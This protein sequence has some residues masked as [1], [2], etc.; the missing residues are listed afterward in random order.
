MGC[1]GNWGLSVTVPTYQPLSRILNS[2]KLKGNQKHIHLVEVKYCEEEPAH[3]HQST[4]QRES[5]TLCD[6]LCQA[7]SKGGLRTVILGVGGTL[8]SPYSK[9]TLENLGL[10][11]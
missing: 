8:C 1:R 2:S 3:G 5:S 6:D 10:A 7:T 4:G 11:P 9:E